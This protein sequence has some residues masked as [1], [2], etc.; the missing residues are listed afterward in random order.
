MC[1]PNGK[2]YELTF[3]FPYIPFQYVGHTVYEWYCK[4][5]NS[6]IE[7]HFTKISILLEF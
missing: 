2:K 6:F 1:G 7:Q 4:E 3:A 5:K